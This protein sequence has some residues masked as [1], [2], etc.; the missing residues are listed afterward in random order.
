MN[1]RT[2]ARGSSLFLIELILSILFFAVASSVCV[3]FFVKARLMSQTSTQLTT[4]V[5]AC[6][7]A[8]QTIAA[9]DSLSDISALL[10]A[11]YPDAETSLDGLDTASV[12]VTLTLSPELSAGLS[13]SG[14][15]LTAK[16]S[17]TPENADTPLYTLT[18][19]KHLTGGEL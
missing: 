4:A 14:H 8:S 11:V 6:S 16:L 9:G 12:P 13:L 3:Q 18:V 2:H 7:T 5:S 1:R 17:W 19:K 15:L 10:S